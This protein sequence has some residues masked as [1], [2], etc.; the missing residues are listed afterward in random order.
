MVPEATS[1]IAAR[2]PRQVGRAPSSGWQMADLLYSH[3]TL[4]PLLIK[5]L[6][7]CIRAPRSLPNYLP[8]AP[9]LNAMTLGM[10]FQPRNLAGTLTFD[11]LQWGN[12]ESSFIASPLTRTLFSFLH[13]RKLRHRSLT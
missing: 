11:S 12:R 9:P 10:A 4:Q 5:A 6:I 13:L 7:P 3:L 2:Q 8:K 1:L